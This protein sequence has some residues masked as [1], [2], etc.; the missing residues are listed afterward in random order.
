MPVDP[1]LIKR[2]FQWGTMCT[3]NCQQKL[4]DL[5]AEWPVGEKPS[6]LV[7]P[8]SMMGEGK[9]GTVVAR[10]GKD[11]NYQ[12]LVHVHNA[13]SIGKQ[14]DPTK[15]WGKLFNMGG[16]PGIGIGSRL[17]RGLT[18]TTAAVATGTATAVKA[19]VCLGSLGTSYACHGGKRTRRR[20]N[21]KN[22]NKKSRRRH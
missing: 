7:S 22:K 10:S 13:D 4:T 20:M 12:L 1:K 18:N 14:I 21:R 15:K 3:K 16:I 2:I 8:D 5:I 19:G 6:Q 17:S 11:D 9:L